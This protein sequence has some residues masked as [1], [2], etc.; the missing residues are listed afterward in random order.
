MSVLRGGVIN[1]WEEKIKEW[2]LNLSLW[3]HILL[4]LSLSKFYWIGP[5]CSDYGATWNLQLFSSYLCL[6]W[7]NLVCEVI[8][9][10]V[11]LLNAIGF[12]RTLLTLKQYKCVLIPLMGLFHIYR[13]FGTGFTQSYFST[14]LYN[15]LLRLLFEIKCNW[16]IYLQSH[17]KRDLKRA[18][19]FCCAK[20]I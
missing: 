5:G 7:V 18:V 8:L 6:L 19:S 17:L 4:V 9:P 14:K 2:H 1:A 16:R 11:I 20:N 12:Y 15:A 3:H 13:N 10:W